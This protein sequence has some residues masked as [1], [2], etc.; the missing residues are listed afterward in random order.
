MKPRLN[1]NRRNSRFF[2]TINQGG[3]TPGVD[4]IQKNLKMLYRDLVKGV[5]QQEK[6]YEQFLTLPAIT[7]LAINDLFS[8]IRTEKIIYEAINTLYLE[9]SDEVIM[10]TP[11]AQNITMILNDPE[12]LP[13]R[14]KSDIRINAYTQLVQRLINFKNTKD[15]R[16][17]ITISAYFGSPENRVVQQVFFE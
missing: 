8:K 11:F 2:E 16:Q 13:T 4:I 17:L 15:V 9:A 7:D 3:L 14:R 5:A 6:Y 10:S 1:Q 12:T